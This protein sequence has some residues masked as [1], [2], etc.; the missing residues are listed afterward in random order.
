MAARTQHHHQTDIQPD[1]ADVRR[2]PRAHELLEQFI[3]TPLDHP[4]RARLRAQVIEAWLPLA[5]ALARRY[6]GRGEPLD[7]IDQ[8]A[9]VGLIKAIDRYQPGRGS[10]FVAFAVPT[11]LGEIRRHF[12]DHTW[13]LRVP[14]RLQEMRLA[15]REATQGLEQELGRSPTSTELA[16]DLDSTRG[17]VE[18]AMSV[19]GAYATLSLDASVSATAEVDLRLGDVVGEDDRDLGLAELRM[20]LAPELARLP[21]REQTILRLRFYGNLSQTEIAERIGISQMHVS[22][23]LARSLRLLRQALTGPGPEPE[24]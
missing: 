10:G 19:G 15:I 14:R 24:S 21:E 2:D 1:N 13:E 23:L 18:E 20:A 11:V 9:C 3:A 7:D 4:A 12:R 17:E 5:H 8:T 22:R 6:D 16:S